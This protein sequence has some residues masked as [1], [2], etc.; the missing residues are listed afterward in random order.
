MLYDKKEYFVSILPYVNTY[1]VAMFVASF[2]IDNTMGAA[3][4]RRLWLFVVISFVK[5]AAAGSMLH[6]AQQFS[7]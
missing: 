2:G 4:S 5:S 6:R 3:A 7:G 1:L